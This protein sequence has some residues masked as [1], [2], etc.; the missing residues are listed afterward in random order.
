[1]GRS[2]S[3]RRMRT[4]LVRK[5][6]NLLDVVRLTVDLPEEGVEAGREG[7]VVDVLVRD[8]IEYYMVEFEPHPPDDLCLPILEAHQ[9]EIV[10]AY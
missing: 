4:D 10:H 5:L 3:L 7:A 1:M 9:L 2:F 8:G 6:F